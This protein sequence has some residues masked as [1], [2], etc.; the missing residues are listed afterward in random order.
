VVVNHKRV[1]RLMREH[2]IVGVHL[3]RRRRTTRRDPAAQAAPDL[4]GRDFTAAGLDRR[5]CGDI[6]CLR[7]ADRFLYLATVLDLH[8]RR[9]VGWSLADHARAELAADALEAAVAT[10]GGTIAGVV[11]FHTDHGAQYS[12]VAFAELC[13]HH[14]VVQS[15]G[16]IGDSLDN[17]VAESFFATLKREF[18]G[19]WASVDQARLAVF[20]WIAFSNHRRRHSAIGITAPSTTRGSP[21][22]RSRTLHEARCPPLGG[23]PA[24]RIPASVDPGLAAAALGS[25]RADISWRLPH[26]P[27]GRAGRSPLPASRSPTPR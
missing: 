1:E 16:R 18:G 25:G 19:R 2:E 15:M 24:P 14:G 27:L 26:D 17:A 12:S 20:S 8:S 9:L 6:T 11:V 23:N 10:R 5:W 7:V 3:R 4:L 13:D 22:T 21:H